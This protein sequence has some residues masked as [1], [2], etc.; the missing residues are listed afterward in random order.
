MR[1]KTPE[2]VE[3]AQFQDLRRGILERHAT[4]KYIDGVIADKSKQLHE[5]KQSQRQIAKKMQKKRRELKELQRAKIHVEQRDRK[6]LRTKQ[7]VPVRVAIADDS[8]DEVEVDPDDEEAMLAL[9]EVGAAGTPIPKDVLEM[10]SRCKEYR[11]AR[12]EL[13]AA[14]KSHG[15]KLPASRNVRTFVNRMVL[16]LRAQAQAAASSA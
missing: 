3:D 16:K 13:E 11:H 5:L 12:Y 7:S 1:Q 2:E 4:T 15:K 8:S 10:N 9:V 6:R 14:M